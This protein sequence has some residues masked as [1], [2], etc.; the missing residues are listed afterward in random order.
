M[1]SDFLS[2]ATGGPL[3]AL[4]SYSI[5]KYG[6]N[7]AGITRGGRSKHSLPP[8][9]RARRHRV[10]YHGAPRLLFASR[11]APISGLNERSACG[12]E[13][14][15]KAKKTAN[16]ALCCGRSVGGIGAEVLCAPKTP[17]SVPPSLSPGYSARDAALDALPSRRGTFVSSETVFGIV[18][19]S[20]LP[21]V[22]SEIGGA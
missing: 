17:P 2:T 6:F 13:V 22:V 21:A 12:F 10:D 18:P 9:F 1:N 7:A 3:I 14:G 5:C 11:R 20:S 4:G 16:N 15:K 8:R 19:C